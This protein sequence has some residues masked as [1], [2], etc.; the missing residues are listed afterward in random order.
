MHVHA[1]LFLSSWSIH[2]NLEKDTAVLTIQNVEFHMCSLVF[3]SGSFDAFI[4]P[5]AWGLP[6]E[7]EVNFQNPQKFWTFNIWISQMLAFLTRN[8]L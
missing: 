1:Y 6:D 5:L 7:L 4:Q 2:K 3:Q 8:N